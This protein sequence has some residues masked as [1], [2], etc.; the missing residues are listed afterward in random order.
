[1]S[2]FIIVIAV[3]ASLSTSLLAGL[4][5]VPAR[6]ASA[7][8]HAA[9]PA[10]E[11]KPAPGCA[12]AV[13]PYRPVNCAD[14]GDVQRRDAASEVSGERILIRQV[15]V[16]SLDRRDGENHAPTPPS[17]ARTAAKRQ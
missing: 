1:M 2:R 17:P 16:I 10:D 3:G 15:R 11:A 12:S 6:S 5:A 4:A 9:L 7:A 8:P 14:V 13:W